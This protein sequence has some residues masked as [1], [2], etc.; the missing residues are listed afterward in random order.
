MIIT[1]PADEIDQGTAGIDMPIESDLQTGGDAEAESGITGTGET[2]PMIGL[3]GAARILLT[4]GPVAEAKII[5]GR[6]QVDRKAR[7]P[8][9]FAYTHRPLVNKW[10]NCLYR[11]PKHQPPLPRLRPR[12][13]Q[14]VLRSWK[15]GRRKWQRIRNVRRKIL[16]Q[17]GLENF[18]MI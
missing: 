14:N 1:D 17:E 8:P 6:L 11:P 5:V 12:R 18:W 16:E 13:R 3:E 7:K 2:T 9:R 4:H 10:L 15:H